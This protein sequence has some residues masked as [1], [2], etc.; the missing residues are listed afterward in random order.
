MC[1]LT[2]LVWFTLERLMAY[3]YKGQKWLPELL[4]VTTD[5]FLGFKGIQH[6]NQRAP[7]VL[8]KLTA[9]FTWVPRFAKFMQTRR[10]LPRIGRQAIATHADSAP[11]LPT[12][13]RKPLTMPVGSS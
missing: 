4:A 7:V 9:H 5:T 1:I 11:A 3:R 13:S 2:I 6:V 8:R 12:I 10:W